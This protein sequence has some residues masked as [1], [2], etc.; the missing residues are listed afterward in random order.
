MTWYTD[1]SEDAQIVIGIVTMFVVIAS[2]IFGFML[3]HNHMQHQHFIE[4][5][6]A[7]RDPDGCAKYIGK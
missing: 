1:L 4:C 7:T 2:L 6:Q 3:L 5:V